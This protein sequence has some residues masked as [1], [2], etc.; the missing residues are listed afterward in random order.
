MGELGYGSDLGR[1]LSTSFGRKYAQSRPI[2]HTIH[3]LYYVHFFVHNYLEI[4]PP[5]LIEFWQR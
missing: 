4:R 1:P 2:R 3:I 5:V